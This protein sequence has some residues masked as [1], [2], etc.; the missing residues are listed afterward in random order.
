MPPGTA[1][2]R[3]YQ[4][5]GRDSSLE[6][7]LSPLDCVNRPDHASAA[8]FT[9]PPPARLGPRAGESL[10]P[11]GLHAAA[12]VDLPPGARDARRARARAAF[13]PA[14]AAAPADQPPAVRRE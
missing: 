11:A 1:L 8:R 5:R 12:R 13:R 4:S 14:R 2:G 10:R 7:T 3:F 9:A 6:R